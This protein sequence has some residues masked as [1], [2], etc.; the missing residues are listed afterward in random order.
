MGQEVP[1]VRYA[2]EETVAELSKEEKVSSR[3]SSW[4]SSKHLLTP[5][6]V[7]IPGTQRARRKEQNRLAQ[8]DLRRRRMEHTQ[9]VSH[10]PPALN[11]ETTADLASSRVYQLETRVEELVRALDKKDH[12]IRMLQDIV[13]QLQRGGKPVSHPNSSRSWRIGSWRTS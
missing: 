10:G 6:T 11:G 9:N 12:E 1:L 3:S 7:C 5:T 13:K 8:Q 2:S 4:S